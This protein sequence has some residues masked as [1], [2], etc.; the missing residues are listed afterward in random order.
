M[1]EEILKIVN[2]IRVA[3]GLSIVSELKETDKLRDDLGL[4]SFDLAELTV[5]IEDI[6]D[7]DIFAD[8]L[9]NNI[10]EIYAKLQD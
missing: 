9:V 10:G 4:T 5:K 6:Y 3:K 7:I 2:D 1:K 8:G